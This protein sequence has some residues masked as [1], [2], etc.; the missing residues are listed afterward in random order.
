MATR[1]LD[2]VPLDRIEAQARPVN[3]GRLV[4]AALVGV[5]YVLGWLAAKI[6][7]VAGV[8]LGWAWAALRTGWA[9][10]HQPAEERRRARAA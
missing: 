10:A 9:D 7:I 8:A 2:R 6:V 3:L 1:L 4:M 5:F